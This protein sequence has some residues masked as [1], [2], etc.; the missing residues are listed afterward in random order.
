MLE[1]EHGLHS[2]AGGRH[3]G[4]GTANRIVPLGDSYVE[5][6]AI[7][8]EREAASSVLGRWVRRKATRAGCPIGWCVRPDDLAATASRLDLR[9]EEGSRLKPSGERID[10]RTAGVDEAVSS[11]ELPFFIERSDPGTFPGATESPA[12]SLARLEITG[13]ASRLAAWLG[14]HALPIEVLPGG[15]GV[16]A[17]TLDGPRGPITFA[18]ASSP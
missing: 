9:I 4:W 16:T 14:P 13:D 8:D 15:A 6:I 7:V 11:P 12:A 3:P 1:R 5:L 10:W 17:V 18:A 2:V